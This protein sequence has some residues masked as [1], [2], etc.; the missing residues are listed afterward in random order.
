[1]RITAE[2]WSLAG[3]IAVEKGR[4]LR[5]EVTS[6]R[7]KEVDL[8]SNDERFWIWS[9]EMDPGFVTCKHENMEIARQQVGI[10]FEPDWLMQA[11]GVAPLLT[12]GVTMQT[13]PANEQIRLVE[14]IVAA[15]GQP[16]RRTV[17]VDL[18]KGGVVTEHGLY[19]YNSRP[20]ALARLSDHRMDKE[21]GVVLPHR[22]IIELPQNKM[23]MTMS[24]G[25]I[26]VNPKSIPSV[27]WQMPHMRDCEVVNLDA[28]IPSGGIRM[29]T[30]PDTSEPMEGAGPI[31]TIR[32]HDDHNFMRDDLLR[33]EEAQSD[34]EDNFELPEESIGRARLSDLTAE[35]PDDDNHEDDWSK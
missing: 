5:L 25:D 4:H 16:L 15:H 27:V 13:D 22:V 21:S 3:T 33:D 9:R 1:V 31:E 11:L 28:G 12:S 2:G 24:L 18:K 8:G 32:S 34:E 29:V 35:S 20:I 19:D 17:V 6:L 30:R 7:G 10:P 23:V 26:L 14:H